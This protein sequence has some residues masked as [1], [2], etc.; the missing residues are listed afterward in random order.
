MA[1]LSSLFK[2]PKVLPPPKPEPVPRM[3]D[4]NDPEILEARRRTQRELLAGKGRAS[5][6]LS[7]LEADLTG[8]DAGSP[9]YINEALGQ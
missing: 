5:T 3:P 9:T 2:A 8:S 6:I 7:G 1:G 4:L